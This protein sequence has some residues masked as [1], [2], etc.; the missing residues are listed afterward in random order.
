MVNPAPGG[1]TSTAA[2]FQVLAVPTTVYVN[3]AY[4][5]DPFG[6]VVTWTDGSKHTV[7][8][9]AFGTVQAG[10]TAVAS[11]GTVNIAAGTYIESVRIAQSL[12]L[13]GAGAAVTT[14][15]IP[16]K[17]CQQRRDRD[18]ERGVRRRCP[19]SQSHDGLLNGTGIADEGGTLLA[20]DIGV[21]GF[22]NGVAV[23]D[24]RPPR[25]PT[26]RSPATTLKSWWAQARATPAR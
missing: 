15:Q 11:G 16:A 17:V 7:G 9:D 19:A 6:T 20:T 5:A 22:E 21:A 18:R 13:A 23:Q 3:A 1:G 24:K 10:V 14:I 25:S 4:A 8:Y 26:A 12:T 2:T